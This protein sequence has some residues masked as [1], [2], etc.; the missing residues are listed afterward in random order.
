MPTDIEEL[1]EFLH[2][3][4]PQLRQI[5]IENLEGY[6]LSQPA[7]FRTA[8]FTPIKDLKLLVRDKPPIAKHALTILI[9][10]ST[11]RN[12]LAHLAPDAS[13]GDAVLGRITDAS[14]TNADLAAMLLAN[15][16]KADE[17]KR[18]VAL[19]RDVPK[20]DGAAAQ[21][22]SK[23]ALD[24]LVD[25]FVRGVEGRWN[26]KADFDYLAYFFADI[27]KFPEGRQYFT[28]TRDYDG[29]VP[30]SKLV[31]FTEHKSDIRRKGVASTIK[32][33]SFDIHTHGLLISPVVDILPY[34]LLPLAGNED[35]P[36]EETLAMHADL[37]LLPPDKTRDSDPAILTTHLE[38]LLLLTTT[39]PVR[40]LMREIMV[41][42]IVRE[43]HLHVE[44]EVVREACDRLVQVLARDEEE[45]EKEEAA[46]AGVGEDEDEESKVIEIF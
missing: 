46:E 34:L 35:Y 26:K 11:D 27:A 14:D 40:E 4:N 20:T 3:P 23:R 24:Q 8:D 21:L 6:S 19:E 32:N 33:V 9:N 5:A 16:A 25:V 37:Q 17:L 28:K 22:N 12:I 44:D 15:L 36:E 10:L 38:T 45:A 31:I 7:I 42:P 1:V 30:I 41:Y 29:V 13:F 2:H 43:T 39:R 18:V